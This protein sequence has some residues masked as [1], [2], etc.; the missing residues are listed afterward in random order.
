MSPKE[1]LYIQDALG[2]ATETKQCCVGFA[3]QIEDPSLK[4]LLQ[5]LTAKQ[6]ETFAKFYALLNN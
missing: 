6:N 1:L 3:A 2:H 5:D 4:T